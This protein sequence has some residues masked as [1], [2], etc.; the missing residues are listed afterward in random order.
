MKH[1]QYYYDTTRLTELINK[2][3]A[4]PQKTIEKF[5]KDNL[6]SELLPQANKICTAENQRERL[7]FLF[8]F[9][10]LYDAIRTAEGKKNYRWLSVE[11]A[12]EYLIPLFAD[13]KDKEH[14]YVF[15]M[16][17]ANEIIGKNL[18]FTGTTNEVHVYPREIAKAAL[19][20]N[21]DSIILSHNHPSGINKPSF[22][23]IEI[24]RR[25]NRAL[26]ELNILVKDHIIVTG[27]GQAYSMVENG[28]IIIFDEGELRGSFI[29][30]EDFL[31][32]KKTK[33]NDN[34]SQKQSRKNRG[35]ER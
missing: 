33:D 29:E 1:K 4:I 30:K 20:Y 12:K 2:F 18:V 23:D 9:K 22:N 15:F 6:V 31:N 7:K 11:K 25:V 21:A 3:T 34:P 19:F 28:E 8:E 24:T 16:N 10:N 27:D 17:V 14:F 32:C 35:R 5:L 26:K 13:V